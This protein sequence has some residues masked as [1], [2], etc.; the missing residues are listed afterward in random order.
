METRIRTRMGDGSLVEM[1]RSELRA[2]I[3]E[4]TEQAARKARVAPLI[5]EEIDHLVD[6]YGSS[7]RFTGVDIGEEVV[8]TMDGS[9]THTFAARLQD[10]QIYE[11]MF[12]TD[13][14]ELCQPDYSYKAV[15]TIVPYEAQTMHDVQFALTVPVQY[16][17][18]PNLGLYSKPDGP[19]ENW[20]EL[21]PLGRIAEARAAQEEAVELATSDMIHIADALV[22]GGVD[23]I[24][25]DTAG[26][27]GDGD[28][29]A[30]LR[31]V[32]AIRA[33]HPDL[34]IQVGMAGE[35]VLGMH[36][37]L[38][39]EGERLAGLWPL[40]QMRLASKAGATVF[41]PAINTNTGKSAA[42][43]VARAITL[44]KPCVQRAEIPIHMNV[45]MGVG[46]VP[47]AYYPPLDA[48]SRASRA[49]VE[50]LHL[51]GL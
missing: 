42:W 46:G 22:E 4:G 12:C 45:G 40:D 37:A 47:M 1:T 41:G 49:C 20:S 9:G 14:V 2:D 18:M 36:G 44:V 3:E 24:D 8:L 23:G 16:G 35:F 33:K 5:E 30:T 48:V 15:R 21:L 31:A 11:Q 28:F 50:L 27:A 39:Y 25:F 17:A 34:G 51:D 43:N 10:L 38:A 6:I 13:V 7:S 19:C 26:A 32:Q 29:L